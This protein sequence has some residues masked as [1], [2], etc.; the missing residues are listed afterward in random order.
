MMLYSTKQLLNKT[1][2][3]INWSFLPVWSSLGKLVVLR[4][5]INFLF[6]LFWFL[7]SE[8]QSFSI[9]ILQISQKLVLSLHSTNYLLKALF[10]FFNKKIIRLNKTTGKYDTDFFVLF[11]RSWD[12]Y[13]VLKRHTVSIMI[14]VKGKSYSSLKLFP[15]ILTLEQTG[16][17]YWINY[18][19]LRYS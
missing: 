5:P 14:Q 3:I 13:I 15:K 8:F 2:K 11:K 18:F 12:L 1:C 10:S 19:F 7:G 9:Y 17:F 4:V 16:F 6:V